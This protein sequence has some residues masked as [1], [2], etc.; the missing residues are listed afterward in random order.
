MLIILLLQL[1]TSGNQGCVKVGTSPRNSVHISGFSK[2]DFIRNFVNCD[3]SAKSSKSLDLSGQFSNVVKS[4]PSMVSGQ[5]ASSWTL[6]LSDSLKVRQL[7]TFDRYR[8]WQRR[9]RRRNLSVTLLTLISYQHFI[10]YHCHLSSHFYLDLNCDNS[11]HID[12]KLRVFQN[13][14]SYL[15]F[16]CSNVYLFSDSLD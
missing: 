1:Q 2:I 16:L 4:V 13:F 15:A 10:I 3:K 6:I 11:V 9:E 8:V 5:D 7:K 14:I 12:K